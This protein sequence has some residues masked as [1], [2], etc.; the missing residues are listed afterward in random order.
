MAAHVK[1][2]VKSV[3][4][5]PRAGT[6]AGYTCQAPHQRLVWA[7]ARSRRTLELSSAG[8]TLSLSLRP[9]L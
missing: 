3:G 2:S 8:S 9:D 6:P 4:C 5:D 7:Q 1:A